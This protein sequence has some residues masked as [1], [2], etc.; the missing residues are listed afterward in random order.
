M[1]GPPFPDGLGYL[2]RWFHDL[3]RGRSVSGMGY[4]RATH[5]D[6]LAWQQNFGV[7]AQPWELRA[8]M[9]L[10]IVWMNVMNEETA[11]VARPPHD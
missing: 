6:M 4:T 2:W 1:A 8:L 5:Q 3:H 10:G 7:R 11:H 9:Q